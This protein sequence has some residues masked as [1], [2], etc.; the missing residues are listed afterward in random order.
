MSTNNVFAKNRKKNLNSHFIYSSGLSFYYKN[1][2]SLD[3]WTH[4]FSYFSWNTTTGDLIKIAWQVI[5]MRSTITFLLRKGE[6]TQTKRTISD[7][8]RQNVQLDFL[9]Y[10]I[11]TVT[12]SYKKNHIRSV[13]TVKTVFINY[14]L[15]EMLIRLLRFVFLCEC[16]YF[17]AINKIFCSRSIF[18]LL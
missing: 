18:S 5:P 6:K 10:T 8:V 14:R 2:P 1:L 16:L 11:K 12:C 3:N 9:L 7:Y 13:Y 4:L 17:S 15:V